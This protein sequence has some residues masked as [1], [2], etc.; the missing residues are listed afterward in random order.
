ME[1]KK[2]KFNFKCMVHSHLGYVKYSAVVP[3]CL[4]E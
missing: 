2:I 3:V 4:A 1:M